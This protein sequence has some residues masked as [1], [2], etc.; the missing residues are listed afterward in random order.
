MPDARRFEFV[1]GTSKK[2]WEVFAAG[3]DVTVRFGRI[4]TDGQTQVKPHPTEAA[5]LSALEKLIKEKTG[6]GYKE[7]GG[8][9]ATAAPAKSKEA[10]ETK[11][12]QPAAPAKKLG[13]ESGWVDAGG[14]YQLSLVEGKLAAAKNGA[15]LA[16]VPKPLKEG[17]LAERLLAAAEFLASHDKGCIESVESWMLRS[18]ATP[19]KILSAVFPDASWRKALENAVVLPVDKDGQADRSAMGFFRGVDPKKGIGV[20]DADGE[21]K[22]IDA[23]SVW[24]PHPVVLGD[25]LDDLRGLASELSLTQGISQLFREVFKKPKDLQPKDSAIRQFAR[26]EFEML[27]HAMGAAKSQGYRVTGGSA[28]CRVWEGGK[29]YEARYYLGDGDPMYETTTG[30]L[31]WVDEKQKQLLIAEVPPIAFS[32]GMRM[33]A[34]I[35]AKRKIEKEGGEES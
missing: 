26:A 4:G 3:S 24:I 17:D 35:H 6:K 32:E 5:A 10:K 18:L 12:K 15:R 29:V 1:E 9:K 25:A 11:E 28:I 13:K 31:E 7:V 27:T 2:F 16:S 20:V 22:W 8:A 21:T 33:A 19:R 34:G 23:P 30:D 14:G